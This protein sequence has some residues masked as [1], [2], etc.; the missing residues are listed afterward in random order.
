MLNTITTIRLPDGKQVAFVDWSDKPLFSTIELIHGFTRQEIDMFGFTV[1]DPIPAA[2][3]AGSTAAQRTSLE[4]DTNLEAPA[5]MASTEERM[6]YAIKPEIFALEADAPVNNRFQMETVVERNGT[7]Q[8]I[9]NPVFLGILNRA[10]LL[11]LEITQKRFARA[12]LGYFNTGFGVHGAGSTMDSAANTGR[13]YATPGLPSQEAV[14]SY[15]VPQYMGGQEK[16]RVFITNAGGGPVNFGFSENLAVPINENAV[17]RLRVYL[18][19][20]YKRPVA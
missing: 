10:L 12:G 17:A 5:S 1:G 6:V 19:G 3:P 16:F 15:V 14:R 4:S 7:G 9:P 13:T 8:P 11:T 18:E 2:A 20:L